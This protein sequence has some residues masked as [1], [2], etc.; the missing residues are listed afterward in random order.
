MGNEMTEE[1]T[2]PYFENLKRNIHGG[3]DGVYFSGQFPEGA[4]YTLDPALGHIEKAESGEWGKIEELPKAE[5][6]AHEKA[7]AEGATLQELAA[8]DLPPHTLAL[9]IAGDSEALDKVIKTE[10]AKDELRKELNAIK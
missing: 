8:L 5:K 4:P 1:S 2:A 6:E 9:A 10:S 3:I 7:Q